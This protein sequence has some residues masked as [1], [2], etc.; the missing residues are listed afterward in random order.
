MKKLRSQ[1][2]RSSSVEFDTALTDTVFVNG[3]R[4]FETQ[5]LLARRG[6]QVVMATRVFGVGT[7]LD[8]NLPTR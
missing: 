7:L 2:P 1:K 3:L 5:A 4:S 8:N 6:F